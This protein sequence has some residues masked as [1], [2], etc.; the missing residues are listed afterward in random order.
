[1]CKTSA[2]ILAFLVQIKSWFWYYRH[3]KNKYMYN[4]PTHLY[5]QQFVTDRRV[6]EEIG[7]IT[8]F[9]AD[10]DDIL[11]HVMGFGKGAAIYTLSHW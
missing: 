9:Q 11:R 10:L 3:D 8:R 1:M 7:T 2:A 6:D 5:A 4:T